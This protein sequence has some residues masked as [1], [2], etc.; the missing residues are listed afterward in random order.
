VHDAPYGEYLKALVNRY[1]RSGMFW[2]ANRSIHRQPITMWQIWNEPDLPYFWNTR[3]FAR[4]YVALLRVA[5][6]A[7]KRAD[8]GAKVV[9]ASLTGHSWR[10]LATIYAIKRARSL[11]D[12]VAENTYAPSPGGVI[13]VLAH[14]R[15]VMDRNGDAGKPL[16]DTEVGWP[17]ARG[18]TTLGLG[19]ATTESGQATKL[20]QLLPMLAANRKALG[21]AGFYYYTWMSSDQYG[22]TSPFAFSGLLKYGSHSH[23]VSEKPAFAIFRRI[24]MR[25]E[26]R[27]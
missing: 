20:G 17:S 8:P 25:L 22:S 26:G 12:V 16:L 9:L 10:G 13:N 4:S 11:F 23:R 1:G 18:K 3:H 6:R 21:L 24:V 7:I 14:V 15:K 19:V 2:S 27:H 5:H